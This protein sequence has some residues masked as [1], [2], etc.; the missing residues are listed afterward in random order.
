MPFTC[1]G[2]AK[3]PK[4]NHE[5]LLE[6]KFGTCASAF[7]FREVARNFCFLS[8]QSC[9]IILT[10]VNSA[11]ILCPLLEVK[12]C[13]NQQLTALFFFHVF[14]P[15]KKRKLYP[16]FF[17]KFLQ[18]CDVQLCTEPLTSFAQLQN[19]ACQ[20]LLQLNRTTNGISWASANGG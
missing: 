13:S 12:A 2:S 18:H 9:T 15:D 10:N 5:K 1:A 4:N 3:M 6:D 17:P 19:E 16:F 20:T 8:L 7:H 14:T 11:I